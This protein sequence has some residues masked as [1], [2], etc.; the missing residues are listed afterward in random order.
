[1]LHSGAD[2]GMQA[3]EFIGRRFEEQFVMDLQD[4]A[5]AEF[6][7]GKF[8]MDS[9]HGQLDEIGS[10]ALKGRVERRFHSQ[11]SPLG[12]VYILGERDT[13]RTEPS[14]EELAFGDALVSLVANTYVNYVLDRDMRRREFDLLSRLVARVPVRRIR[15]SANPSG[16]LAMC[17]A[18]AADARRAMSSRPVVTSG[19]N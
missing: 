8:A 19:V 11:A 12:A 7:R 4:H 3:V 13:E 10:C 2:E 16:V 15:P 6:L 17:E 14:I 1:M 5:R 9:D 18:I